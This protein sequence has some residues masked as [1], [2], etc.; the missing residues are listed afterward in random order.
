MHDIVCRAN[1]SNLLFSITCGNSS[2]TRQNLP[3]TSIEQWKFTTMTMTTKMRKI[4]VSVTT[5]TTMV[6]KN[7]YDMEATNDIYTATA[8]TATS[9][10][11]ITTIATTSWRRWRHS[12]LFCL[13]D[14][15]EEF[16]FMFIFTF[17]CKKLTSI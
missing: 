4:I 17:N 6:D 9:T 12:Y 14:G 7:N 3:L 13:H 2:P 16:P 8:T 10:M 15:D 11:K 1:P 5:S